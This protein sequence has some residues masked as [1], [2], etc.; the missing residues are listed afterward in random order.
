VEAAVTARIAPGHDARFL[1]EYDR[2]ERIVYQC[3]LRQADHEGVGPNLF[4]MREVVADECRM[5]PAAV[6]VLLLVMYE[7]NVVDRGVGYSYFPEADQTGCGRRSVPTPTRLMRR[8]FETCAARRTLRDEIAAGLHV[9]ADCSSPFDLTVDHIHPI[10]VGGDNS[11]D[12]L[13]VLC[14][15]CNSRKGMRV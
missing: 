1:R 5:D 2:L 12:N 4:D 15:S 14:G 13:R 3:L 9:C 10:A 8:R 7:W 11:P 6:D